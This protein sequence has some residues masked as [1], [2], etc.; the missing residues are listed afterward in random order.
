VQFEIE[1]EKRLDG[2]GRSFALQARFAAEARALVLFGP[3]GSGKSLTLTALAGLL[4]PDAGRICVGG[5]VLFDASARVNLPARQRG[6]GYLFQDYA[7]FP[8]LSVRKNVAFGLS[9]IL[10]RPGREETA[11]VDELL[12]R[13]GLENLAGSLPR[14]LSGGQKQRVALAR[15]LAPRPSLL[16]LDEPFSALDIPLRTRLRAE[17]KSLLAGL[18][19]PL[20]L[21]TH[22]PEEAE[23]FGQAFVVYDHG[24]VTRCFGFDEAAKEGKRPAELLAEAFAD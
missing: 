5:R 2:G 16:L 14:D 23:L 24:K 13:F 7:L 1:I 12:A 8:H 4:T 17:L 19:I 22:D 21:V 15:A 9:G 10:R 18:A 20:V 6:V 3:S 11:R